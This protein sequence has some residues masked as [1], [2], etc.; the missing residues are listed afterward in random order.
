MMMTLDIES[1]APVHSIPTRYTEGR[2]FLQH[3]P[4][5]IVSVRHP[6]LVSA[7][8]SSCTKIRI[9]YCLYACGIVKWTAQE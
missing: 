5:S 6:A 3:P 4:W 1:T 9:K 7:R 8:L 2:M